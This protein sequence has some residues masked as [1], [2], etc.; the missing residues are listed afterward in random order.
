MPVRRIA[1][2]GQRHP[3]ARLEQRQKRQDEGARGTGG[4]H[5]AGGIE[6][7]VVG[8]FVMAGD[9][10]PQRRYAQRLGIAEAA[11]AER[12][13]R[14]LQG[15]GGRRPR[16]L[17]HFHVHDSAARGL[18]LGCRRHHVHDDKRRHIAAFGGQ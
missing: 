8:L 16:R 17:A 6:R 7:E 15:G 10:G 11:R 13:L 2:I 1:G 14:R 5:H 3:V 9:A 12:L 4:H 18:D